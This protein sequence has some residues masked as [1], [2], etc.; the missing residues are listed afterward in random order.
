MIVSVRYLAQV[1]Q[2]AG[3][4]CEQRSL[5][6]GCRVEDLIGLL[7]RGNDSLRRMLLTGDGRVQPTL[8]IF[9]GDEQARGDRLLDD[10]DEV[11]LMT[12]IA[13]GEGDGWRSAGR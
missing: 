8:L 12:P 13:G 3:C 11:T 9:V 4:S 2:A 10:G 6:A 7:A 5:D 1:K